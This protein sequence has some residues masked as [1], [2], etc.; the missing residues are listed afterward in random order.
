MNKFTYITLLSILIFV[1]CRKESTN[2]RIQKAQKPIDAVLDTF[3][4]NQ[5]Q[6]IGSHNS[7]RIKT[8][9]DIFRQCGQKWS[10]KLS[11][12]SITTVVMSNIIETV[13]NDIILDNEKSKK[14]PSLWL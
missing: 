11:F 3:R 9:P 6:C 2:A 5:I 1:A 8:D 13:F 10:K 14:M 4:M 12:K 7:Y